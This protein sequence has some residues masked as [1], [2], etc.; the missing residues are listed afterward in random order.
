MNKGR[1][2][3][4]NDELDDSAGS[5]DNELDLYHSIFQN[6]PYYIFLIDKGFNVAYTNYFDLN[7]DAENMEPMLL[8]N[9]LRCNNAIESGHCGSHDLCPHCIIRASLENAFRTGQPVSEVEAHLR[10]FNKVKAPVD[11]DVTVAAK[12]VDIES[13]RYLVVC[14]RDITTFK[15][16]QRRFIKNEYRLNSAIRQTE[17]YLNLIRSITSSLDGKLAAM[18]SMAKKED[19]NFSSLEMLE[20]YSTP[21]SS[22]LPQLLVFCNNDDNFAVI[23]SFLGRSYRLLRTKT[24]DE[25]LMFFLNSSLKAVIIASDISLNEANMLSDVVHCSAG[26]HPVLRLI[27][28]GD[29]PAGTYDDVMEEPFSQEQLEKIFLKFDLD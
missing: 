23:D 5:T 26:R 8:G 21:I 1:T 10:I 24:F 19:E 15:A 4:R 27:R 7:T 25:S 12:V 16:L 17:V 28:K 22:A 14:V 29:S 9:V 6:L 20:K 13:K 2:S 11:T 18:K 3:N